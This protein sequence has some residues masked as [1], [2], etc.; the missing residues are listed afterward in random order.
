MIKWEIPVSGKNKEPQ[1]QWVNH[2]TPT[3]ENERN[4]MSTSKQ[5]RKCGEDKPPKSFSP[6]NRVCN[7]CRR[8][9][10]NVR[11]VNSQ[12]A[13][14]SRRL[15]Q[16]RGRARTK[17]IPFSLTPSDIHIPERCPLLDIPLMLTSGGGTRHQDPDVWSIDRIDSS[18]GYTPDNVWVISLRANML[19]KDATL[20][21]LELLT[22]NLRLKLPPSC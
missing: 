22:A 9:Q 15:T 7:A 18:K 19:K 12:D 17:N 20:T 14:I 3:P 6:R 11:A 21:E 16:I 13:N 1:K 8:K 10:A 2:A 4:N 5:C